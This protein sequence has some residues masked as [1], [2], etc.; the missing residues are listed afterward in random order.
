MWGGNGCEK[1]AR[2]SSQPV[3]AEQTCVAPLLSLVPRQNLCNA[4]QDAVSNR[5]TWFGSP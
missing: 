4:Y 5:A 3:P 2:E 1:E